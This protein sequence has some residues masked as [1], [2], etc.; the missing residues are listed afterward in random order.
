M[1]WGFK[2]AKNGFMK[3]KQIKPHVFGFIDFPYS[4]YHTY[5]YNLTKKILFQG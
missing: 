4:F 5:I 2:M 1:L 3:T